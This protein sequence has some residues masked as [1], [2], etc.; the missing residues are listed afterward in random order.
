M[1]HD[2]EDVAHD[3]HPA[4]AKEHALALQRVEAVARWMD[5]RYVDPI[6]GFALPGLGD[7]LGTLIG[8]YTV[9]LARQMGYP[10]IVLARMLINLSLDSLIGAVPILGALFDIAYRAN[11]RNLAL[12]RQRPPRTARPGDWLIVIAAF[13]LIVAALAVPIVTLVLL[14]RA[15][16]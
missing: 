9:N 6:L 15:V 16:F 13:M 8:L 4:M 3:A 11:T 2:A 5:T 14:V 10:K 7:V 12:L 1:G